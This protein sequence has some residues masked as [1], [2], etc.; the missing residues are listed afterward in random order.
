MRLRWLLECL[1]VF[2]PLAAAGAR[3]AEPAPPPADAVAILRAFFAEND[4]A[5]RADLAARF[6][7]LAPAAWDD[8]KAMLHRVAPRPALAPGR[9]T[10]RMA[11]GDG[12]PAITYTL[13]V[14]QG[15]VADGPRGWPLIL[16]TH[17]TGGSGEKA[18]E[19]IEHLL[20]PDVEKYLVAGPDSPRGGVYEAERLTIAYPVRLLADV[21]R[22]ANVDA[23]RCVLTGYS[24]GGYTTWGTVLFSPGEWAGAVPMASW[25]LTE[26][27]SAGTVLFLP[28]VLNLA[29][30]AHWGADD[31]EAG[32]KEGINT[33]SR[34][35]A[36]EMK[37]L[38][39]KHFEPVEYAGQGHG[40]DIRKDKVRAF[41]EAARR[42]PFPADCRLLFHRLYQGR[43]YY[44]RATA[45]ATATEEF[46]FRARR[47]LKV[48]RKQDFDKAKR[49][50]WR[51]E[52]YE[53]TARLPPGKNL[54]AVFARNLKEIEID[55]PA[56]R[57][58]FARPITLTVN[59]RTAK[60]L[61]G[62]VDWTCLLETARETYDFE[63]LIAGRIRLP[64]GR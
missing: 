42:D 50:L 34:D 36:A 62:P 6:G 19:F 33:L 21:R 56:E 49:A 5:R 25:P 44:V 40:L 8:L 63:R 43:A 31:I 16:S 26:A 18:V 10:L 2:V 27:G 24:R 11:G 55:L 51:R 12:I 23:D 45:T 41:L 29:V 37:R 57:L 39:A 58:D 52:G 46:D 35:A 53:L 61:R 13:R 48:A 3:A 38:G 54:V 7:P 14:P 64:A 47:V 30:Q 60:T 1:A 28:N 17:G 32:Q 20:G 15:Y 22:Q 59:G 9:H 4:A